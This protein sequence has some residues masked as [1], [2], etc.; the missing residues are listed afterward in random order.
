M[1]K[2]FLLD[3]V[4]YNLKKSPVYSDGQYSDRGVDVYYLGG[5]RFFVVP[6]TKW[7]GEDTQPYIESL[8]EFLSRRHPERVLEALESLGLTSKLKTIDD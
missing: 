6:W 8:N 2:K 5:E 1:A 4:I 3:G 7:Q